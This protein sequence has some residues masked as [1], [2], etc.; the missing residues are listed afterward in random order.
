MAIHFNP[1]EIIEAYYTKFTVPK[2]S[3]R[4]KLAQERLKICEACSKRTYLKTAKAYLCSNCGCII[5][6]K[7]FSKSENPCPEKKWSCD[8][9][10][11]TELEKKPKSKLI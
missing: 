2:D 4:Y 1:V 10:Y 11:F 8:Q 6:G 7:V 5:G 9:K 3:P